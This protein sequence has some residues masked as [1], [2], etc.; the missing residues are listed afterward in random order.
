ML[1]ILKYEF[2]CEYCGEKFLN[3]HK[4]ARFCCKSCSHKNRYK[5]NIDKNVYENGWN[6]ENAYLFGLIMSDGCLT[7]N[8]KRNIIVIS[9]ND[10]EIIEKLHKYVE[11][12]RKIYKQ[13]KQSKLYYWNE[14]AISFLKKI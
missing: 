1:F 11:C 14:D 13:G 2:V 4:D 7:K 10:F 6:R 9:L 12:K 5:N 8:K 3:H